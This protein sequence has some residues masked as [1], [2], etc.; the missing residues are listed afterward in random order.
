M[1]DQGWEI[2]IDPDSDADVT[3]V[4]PVTTDCPATGA[5][6]TGDGKAQPA[7]TVHAIAK[8]L[9]SSCHLFQVIGDLVWRN[10]PSS[11]VTC[12]RPLAGSRIET[13]RW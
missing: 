11:L 1:S 12:G 9:A 5:I 13:L 8:W 6:G 4:L 10:S 7:A 3:V 2:T